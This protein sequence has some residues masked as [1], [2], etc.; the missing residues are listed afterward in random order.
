MK[1]IRRL[2]ARLHANQDRLFQRAFLGVRPSSGP[3]FA[4]GPMGHNMSGNMMPLLSVRAKLD[5][6]T[7]ASEQVSQPET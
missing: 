7:T 2:T 4:N 6:R 5:T 3:W 1:A